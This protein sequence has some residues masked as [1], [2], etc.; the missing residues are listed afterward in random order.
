MKSATYPGAIAPL[1]FNLYK[2]DGLSVAIWIAVSGFKPCFM[3]LTIDEFIEPF[4]S[5]SSI[6]LSSVQRQK[7]VL[8]FSFTA[9]RR[10]FKFLAAVP[11]RI[12]TYIPRLT[13]SRASLALI[14]SWSVEIFAVLYVLVIIL[15]RPAPCPSITLEFPIQS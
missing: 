11:S 7:R 3:H 2:T 4:L 10:S 6:C 5:M 1:L 8:L 9:G 14:H 13:F 15:E 12:S